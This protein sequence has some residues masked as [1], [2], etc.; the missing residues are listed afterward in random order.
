MRPIAARRR[1]GYHAAAVRSSQGRPSPRTTPNQADPPPVEAAANFDPAAFLQQDLITSGPYAGAYIVAPAGQLNWY[2]ANVGLRGFVQQFP[3]QIKAYLNIYLANMRADYTIQDVDDPLAAAPQ[4]VEPD[5][6]NS[7]AA[8]FISLAVAYVRASNDTAWF[9]ANFPQVRVMAEYNLIR[10]RYANGLTYPFQ[11]KS[12]Y[13]EALLEDNCEVYAALSDLA[14]YLQANGDPTDATYY[15]TEASDTLV[16][17]ETLFNRRANSWYVSYPQVALTT[18]CYPDMVS[19]VFAQAQGVPVPASWQAAGYAYLNAHELNWPTTLCGGF[20]WALLGYVA[21][22]RGD[23]VRAEK[24]IAFIR[25][26]AQN[27]QERGTLSINEL[28]WYART[29]VVLGRGNAA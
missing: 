29:Q 16:G 13:D 23:T 19:Q 6:N 17:I 14:S 15:Q 11:N 27:P 3:A 20:P 24:Q 26:L 10:N 2:F 9:S 4:L 1:P 25:S 22:L 8:T 28:G 7:Y 5:S 21:A 18:A 12:T